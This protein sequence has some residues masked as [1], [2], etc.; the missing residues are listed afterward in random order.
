MKMPSG[1]GG[2]QRAARLRATGWLAVWI[3]L[4][5]ALLGLTLDHTHPYQGDETYYIKSAIGMLRA[6]NL[7]VPQYDGVIR[8]QKPVLAYWMTSLG[9]AVFGI[10]L[11]AGRV[12]FLLAAATLL[13]L[14]YRLG[15]V[16]FGGGEAARLAVLLVSA[17]TLFLLFSRVSMT[18]LLLAVCTTAALHFFCRAALAPGQHAHDLTF[19]YLAMGAG[20][21]AKGALALLPLSAV[22]AWLWSTGAR[23]VS[24]RRLIAPRHLATFAA[25]AAPW[26]IYVWLTHPAELQAQLAGEAADNLWPGV[27]AILGH[28]AFYAGALLVYQLPAVGLSAW[29]R[30]K[31]RV[32]AAIDPGLLPLAWYAGTCLAAFVLL[33]AHHRDRYL[34]PVVPVLALIMARAIERNGLARPAGRLAA[35]AAVVQIAGIWVSGFVLGQP[36]HDL[37]RYWDRNLRGGLAVCAMDDREATWVLAIAGGRLAPCGEGARFVLAPAA[38]AAERP[39]DEV[40]RRAAR[41]SGLTRAHGRFSL[42]RDEFVL[43]GPRR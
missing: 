40:L 33:F 4:M 14:V 41:V 32:P 2:V 5:C 23:G 28:L 15:R 42:R 10:S 29:A 30:L 39:D 17:S 3:A 27:S 38:H 9:Y 35:V 37:V 19:A 7:L 18:D 20:F 16:L 25:V 11:W 34:L 31:G 43:L 12:P 21:L 8:L 1:G 6:G 36:L 24:L 22:A 26:Y 13:V